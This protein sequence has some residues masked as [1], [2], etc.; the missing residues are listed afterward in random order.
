M[1][2]VLLPD[3]VVHVGWL[4]Y[5]GNLRTPLRRGTG[6]VISLTIFETGHVLTILSCF[7]SSDTLT[8]LKT[9]FP[10]Y[11]TTHSIFDSM[12]QK[13]AK[14]YKKLMH[15]YC[16]NFGFRQP[17]QVLG[18]FRLTPQTCLHTVSCTSQLIPKCAPRAPLKK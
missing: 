8:W 2:H 3:V 14:A 7:R 5:G 11:C 15:L 16:M 12:R 17:Y 10:C 13:R 9:T 4:G 1:K 18:V 6:A